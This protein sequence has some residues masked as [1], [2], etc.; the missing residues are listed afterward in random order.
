MRPETTSRSA[1]PTCRAACAPY[2]KRGFLSL[3]RASATAHSRA[4]SARR[5]GAGLVR[6]AG[7]R[8]VRQHARSVTAIASR[9]A[10]R[11]VR[12]IGETAAAACSPAEWLERWGGIAALTPLT[13]LTALT[14]ERNPLS[15]FFCRQIGCGRGDA[16]KR[17]TRTQRLPASPSSANGWQAFSTSRRLHR[18]RLPRLAA[19]YQAHGY[20]WLGALAELRIGACLADD[21]GPGQDDPG[22]L[23]PGAPAQR[24]PLPRPH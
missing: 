2:S 3:P 14:P 21:M 18:G 17:S 7:A 19:P 12:G 16:S 5:I 8:S 6:A 9:R 23:A 11:P 15:T 1:A 10:Q 24:T 13:A 22:P 4:R 20:S